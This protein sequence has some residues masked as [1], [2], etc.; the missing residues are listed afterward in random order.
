[1]L[2][3]SYFCTHQQYRMTETTLSLVIS[4][5]AILISILTFVLMNN[6]RQELRKNN[7]GDFSTRPLQL[8]AYERLVLLAERL[9]IPS[10]VSRA[11]QP[12]LNAKEMQL[13]LLEGIKQEFEYNTSQQI[14]VSPAAWDS[15]R[16]LK[17][18]NML[19]INQVASALP[20]H[21]TGTD[22]KKVLLDV[23]MKQEKAALHVIVLEA[24][25]YEAR[26][27]MR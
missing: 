18:Q 26:K 3:L 9:A 13:L 20:E 16:N 23:T 1:M 2:V 4:I 25:N 15:V 10:L 11:G 5:A 6:Q 7:S 21:A 17:E 22:L 27:L 19:V 24:L 8:Q 12:G 14:Y